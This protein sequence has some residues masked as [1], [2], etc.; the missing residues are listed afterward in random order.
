M[1]W[2]ITQYGYVCEE[3]KLDGLGS[4]NA[5]TFWQIFIAAKTKSDWLMFLPATACRLA[6]AS[7]MKGRKIF[8]PGICAPGCI[9]EDDGVYLIL[10]AEDWSFFV[11]KNEDEDLSESDDDIL[12]LFSDAADGACDWVQFGDGVSIK[13]WQPSFLCKCKIWNTYVALGFVACSHS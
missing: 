4:F 7:L 2:R 1:Q 9:S 12:R 6:A 3:G 5:G 8:F 10:N 11:P 13:M